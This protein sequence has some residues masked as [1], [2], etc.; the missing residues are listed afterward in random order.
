MNPVDCFRYLNDSQVRMD[1]TVQQ[2][3]YRAATGESW[4][5]AP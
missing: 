2:M 1:M 3:V 5:D 4:L